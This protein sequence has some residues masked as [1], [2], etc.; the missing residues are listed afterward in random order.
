[1]ATGQQTDS[2]GKPVDDNPNTDGATIDPKTGKVSLP[3]DNTKAGT[4]VVANQTTP[5][6][7][8]EKTKRWCLQ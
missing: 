1:M 7:S 4:E 5:A 8:G 6:G 3:A 2:S